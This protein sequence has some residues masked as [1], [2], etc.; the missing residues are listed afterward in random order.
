M[1]TIL[2]RRDRH[3]GRIAALLRAALQPDDAPSAHY[4]D[5]IAGEHYPVRQTKGGEKRTEEYEKA[6]DNVEKVVLCRRFHAA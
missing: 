5:K 3:K 4:E 1:S 6:A 2:C